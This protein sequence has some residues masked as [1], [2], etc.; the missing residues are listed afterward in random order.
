[1]LVDTHAHLQFPQFDEDVQDVIDRA[2]D[3]GVSH[4]V[5]IGTDVRSSKVAIELAE[6]NQFHATVGFHPHAA[7]SFS[8]DGLKEF[9]TSAGSDTVVA[10]GEIG[11]DFFR[12]RA[13]R[14]TQ[15]EAFRRQL[16]F[17]VEHNLP[18]VIHDRDA[19]D[20]VASILEE[21]AR[22]LPG[23][24]LHCYSAG[25]ENVPKYLELGVHFS[26][27]GQITYPRSN[28]LREAVSSI[29][30]DRILLETDAPYQPPQSVRG[31]RN[32]PSFLTY[33]AQCLAGLIRL[34]YDDVCRITSANAARFFSIELG[35]IE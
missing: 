8:T 17:A 2:V 29:P 16:D 20:E 6:R 28:A 24:V 1:M 11:L 27:S 19:H 34:S 10:V 3:E 31:R 14:E 32:E 7:A 13:P 15:V 21:Y 30:I 25:V 18:V 26:V 12:N 4:V 22:R 5:I 23:V 35:V 9:A 33:T